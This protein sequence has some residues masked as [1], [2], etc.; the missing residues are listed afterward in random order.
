[1]ALAAIAG[2]AEASTAGEPKLLS[3]Q[4]V[5][6]GRTSV[7]LPTTMNAD[8]S[9]CTSY[10][11]SSSAG[12]DGFADTSVKQICGPANAEG[13]APEKLVSMKSFETNGLM[14]QLPTVQVNLNH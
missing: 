9:I 11:A 10:L 2:Q 13:T 7:A 12:N 3:L 4:Y 1:M 8:G 6:V 14:V 5:T